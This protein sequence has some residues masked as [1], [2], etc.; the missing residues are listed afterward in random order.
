LQIRFT[1]IQVFKIDIPL[2]NIISILK[3]KTEDA[4]VK[5]QKED[6]EINIKRGKISNAKLLQ[7][8]IKEVQKQLGNLNEYEQLNTEGISVSQ[9]NSN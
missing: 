4:G 8:L 6:F 3:S 5:R 1:T 7:R 9:K 2:G